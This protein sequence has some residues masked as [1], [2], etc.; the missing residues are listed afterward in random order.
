[1]NAPQI[2]L[3]GLDRLDRRLEDVRVQSRD[4]VQHLRFDVV[5]V[6]PVGSL[7]R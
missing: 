2:F 7:T 1:M 5:H 6:Q 4:Q 3:L